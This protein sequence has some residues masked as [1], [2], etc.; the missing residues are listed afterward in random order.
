MTMSSNVV[1]SDFTHDAKD[2]WKDEIRSRFLDFSRAD[3][4]PGSPNG[5]QAII[6]DLG[7][8]REPLP[9][10]GKPKLR[11]AYDE[12][13]DWHGDGAT[14]AKSSLLRLQEDYDQ[15]YTS[16]SILQSDV[17]AAREMV[18][19]GRSDLVGL[20]AD[21]K[22]AAEQ[23]HRTEQANQFGFSEVLKA[24]FAGAVTGLLAVGAGEVLAPGALIAGN[25]AGSMAVSAANAQVPLDGEKPDEIQGDFI[26]AIDR[27]K[28]GIDQTVNQLVHDINTLQLPKL[29]DPPDVSPGRTFDPD[30]FGTPDTPGDV[31]RRVRG[32]GKD[33][34]QYE[35]GERNDNAAKPFT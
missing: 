32:S 13:N 20:A 2:R 28:D 25:V 15:V 19:K 34:P 22:S 26:D 16:L 23:Y 35:P 12:L 29:Q 21:F 1:V 4:E 6:D 9:H 3:L 18:A 27:I 17:V 5:L 31:R 33:I 10:D 7:S 30:D 8:L 24:A 14:A 11:Q